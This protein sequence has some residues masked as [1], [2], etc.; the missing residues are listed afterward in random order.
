MVKPTGP[1]NLST[2]SLLIELRKLSNKEKVGFWKALAENLK[3]PRRQRREVNI[4][5]IEQHMET[6]EIAVVPGKVLS[7][8]ELTKK[9]TVAAFRFSEQAKVKINKMG[10]AITIQDFMKENPKAKNARIIG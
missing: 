8:G 1:S 10:K 2:R 5:S 4:T 6:G 7:Q 3:K 9:I